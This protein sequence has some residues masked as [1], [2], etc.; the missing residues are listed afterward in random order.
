[1]DV[2]R[3]YERCWD[4]CL[5]ESLRSQV[6]S[7]PLLEFQRT[8][9]N[10]MLNVRQRNISSGL[11]HMESMMNLLN[12]EELAPLTESYNPFTS[13]HPLLDQDDLFRCFLDQFRTSQLG[14][15]NFGP[16]HQ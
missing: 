13:L 2:A 8:L 5:N 9:T 12:S 3:L 4:F 15:S 14:F 1:M 10:G 16:A 11:G 6:N 7:G